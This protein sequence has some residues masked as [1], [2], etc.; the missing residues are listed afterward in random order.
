MILSQPNNLLFL[1]KKTFA[2]VASGITSDMRDMRASLDIRGQVL[3]FVIVVVFWCLVLIWKSR[4]FRCSRR[5]FCIIGF[6]LRFVIDVNIFVPY[7]DYLSH[8]QHTIVAKWPDLYKSLDSLGA[9]RRAEL[10]GRIQF[11]FWF[12]KLSC[13]HKYPPLNLGAWLPGETA[14]AAVSRNDLGSR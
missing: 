4:F 3:S 2:K 1:N 14:L 8:A 5:L 13:S 7:F 6:V 11:D 10:E 9:E 12:W